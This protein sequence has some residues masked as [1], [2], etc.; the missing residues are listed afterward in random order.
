MWAEQQAFLEAGFRRGGG[1]L[2]T[3]ARAMSRLDRQ[4]PPECVRWV[5]DTYEVSNATRGKLEVRIAR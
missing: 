4:V 3:C 1:A 2:E 5:L